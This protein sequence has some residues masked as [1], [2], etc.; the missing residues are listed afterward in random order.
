MRAGAFALQSRS[1]DL[2]ARGPRCLRC[3]RPASR[4]IPRSPSRAR[5]FAPVPPVGSIPSSQRLLF[6]RSRRV[7]AA[8]HSVAFGAGP[9]RGRKPVVLADCLLVDVAVELRRVEEDL[10][11]DRDPHLRSLSLTCANSAAARTS[12]SGAARARRAGSPRTHRRRSL[13]SHRRSLR[14]HSLPCSPFLL[15]A[16]LALSAPRASRGTTGR[17]GSTGRWRTGASAGIRGG[18][19]TDC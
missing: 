3:G 9:F 5:G 4:E 12:T 8:G 1:S 11:A 10:L 14:R 19:V 13:R 6:R 7:P 2:L 17:P 16:C 18:G 15:G